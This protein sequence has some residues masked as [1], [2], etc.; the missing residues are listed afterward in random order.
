MWQYLTS[1]TQK[2]VTIVLTTHYLEEAEQL[3]KHIAIINKG[4]LV[5][6]GTKEEILA[7]HT[8]SSDTSSY[9]G[10]KLEEV[11]LSLTAS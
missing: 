1:L 9:R 3:C 6:Q 5:A 4:A 10:G 8:N 11:F 7:L 2:G